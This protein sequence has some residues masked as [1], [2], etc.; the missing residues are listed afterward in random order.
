MNRF[1]GPAMW[2]M[3]RLSFSGKFFTISTAIMV[4]VAGLLLSTFQQFQANRSAAH[5]ELR[6]VAVLRPLLKAVSMTQ[7]HRGMS[8]VALGGDK[9]M[10]DSLAEQ[11]KLTDAAFDVV[12]KALGEADFGD[13]LGKHWGQLSGDWKSLR[14]GGM[15]MAQTPNFA[16]H[17]KLIDGLQ[18]FI[19]MLTEEF[20]LI[21]DPEAETYFDIVLA[22]Q[23]VP[24]LTERLGRIRGMGAGFLASKQMT[25]LQITQFTTFLGGLDAKLADFDDGLNHAL[26]NAKQGTSALKDAQSSLGG[27]V[28]AIRAAAEKQIIQ[29]SLSMPAKEYF[30]L[31]TLPIKRLNELNDKTILVDIENALASRTR[32]YDI[33]FAALSGLTLLFVLGCFYLFVGFY[34]SLNGALRALVA[35]SKRVAAGNLSER[36]NIDSKDELAVVGSEFNLMVDA[37]GKT[38]TEVQ[39]SANAVSDSAGHLANSATQLSQSSGQQNDAA[40]HMAAAVEE[41]TVS[42]AE[43]SQ[44]AVNAEGHASESREF[45]SRGQEAVARSVHE[46]EGVANLVTETA[47]QIRALGAESARIGHMVDV[48]KEIADQTNLLALNAAI[49]AA[50]AGESGCGFAVVADEVRKLAERSARAT[51]EIGAVIGSIQQSTVRAVE[52]MESGVGKVHESVA[53]TAH[54]GS[55]MQSIREGSDKVREVIAEIS[56]ALREQSTVSSEVARNVERVAA[57]ADENHGA[58]ADATRTATQLRE[59]SQHML[60]VVRRFQI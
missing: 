37:F 35:S 23:H 56:A 36:V 52:A 32:H 8:S 14:D 50:R 24:A 18:I 38:V 30:D 1:F 57:M 34:L 10:R 39:R 45:S 59:L 60:S 15:Q 21:L 3:S 5:A 46:I 6:G 27:E 54:A 16:A 40:S 47:V 25:D 2:L 43:V 7:A 58:V 28:A 13:E 4:L 9:A 26:R 29:Q 11:T 51:E 55:A 41:M 53:T 20:A 33:Q 19:S 44:Y 49:E 22:S 31:V 42:I 12:A 48:I 17:T